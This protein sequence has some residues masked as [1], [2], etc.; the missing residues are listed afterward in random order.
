MVGAKAVTSP[1]TSLRLA[2]Q[3][4]GVCS[5]IVSLPFYQVFCCGPAPCTCCCHPRWPPLTESPCSRLFYILLHVGTSAVCCLLLSRMVVERIWGKARGMPSGLCAHLFGH[6]HCPVLSGSGAVYR[7]C[8]GTATFHLLQA[9]LLVDLHSPTSLRAQLHKRCLCAV[10]FCMPD[11]H[12]FP[13][14]FHLILISRSK[15]KDF[16]RKKEGRKR[17]RSNDMISYIFPLVPHLQPGIT[18]ASVEASHSSCCSWCLLQPLPIPGT[19]T[20]PVGLGKGHDRQTGAAQDCPSF[21]AVLLTTLGFYSMAGVA[22]VLLFHYYTHPDGC[23]LNKMLLSLH[24]CCCGLLSFLSI[25][26]CIRLKQ[27]HSGLL[28][29]SV[30]SCSIMYLT[31]SALSSRPPE[32]GQNHTLCLPGL[33]KM[34]PQTPDTSL[35]VLSAGIINEA[36]YLAEVFGPLWIVKVY[37]CEIQPSL[38]F[39]CPETVEP[40]EGECQVRIRKCRFLQSAKEPSSAF[41]KEDEGGGK[42]CFSSTAASS[43]FL[44]PGQR[45]GAARPANQEAAPAPPVQA[46]Q[47]SYSYS[48]FH[49]VFFLA[50]LYVMVTLTNW[51]SYEGAELEKTFT[52]GSWTTFWVKVASCWACV[53][54]YLGL[55]LAPFCWSPTQD[56][57]PPLQATL[58]S[59]QY[60]QITNIQSRY[61]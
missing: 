54:L 58:S 5:V 8:A 3:R 31:F 23:L 41:T 51:F 52:T 35:A 7:V 39:C 15:L 12:L 60:C 47:L 4:S 49:F 24:L 6:S 21:L 37:S 53:L 56:P 9:V 20:D 36:S 22:A 42:R 19:R 61:F 45:G 40:E 25:A 10:A 44:S 2:Q 57:Q 48:A 28:Q 55:L 43:P 11:E 17:T 33:S 27:L 46:Q 32:S 16:L 38:S 1:S 29:A 13:G 34:E 30:I 26:P 59:R 18:W 14:T 50:S